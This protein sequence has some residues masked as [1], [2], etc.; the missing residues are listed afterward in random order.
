ML[1]ERQYS[2]S[3]N[4][5]SREPH[6]HMKLRYPRTKRDVHYHTTSF[7][8]KNG[9]PFLVLKSEAQSFENMMVLHDH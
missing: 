6:W 9:V 2:N 4:E 8:I 7:F 5:R 1:V 3:G